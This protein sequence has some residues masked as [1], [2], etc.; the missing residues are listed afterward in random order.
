MAA[1]IQQHPVFIQAQNKASMYVNQLDKELTQYPVL[2]HFEQRTQIPKAYA[3]I[4]TL[5]LAVILH[6]FNPLASPVSNL[7][8][9]AIESPSPHDDVQWL[10]YWVVFGFLNFLESFAL[11][12]VLY[13]VPWYFAFKSAFI[14]WL[15]LPAFRG[16]Q[17]IYF[18]VLKP[19][20]Q[21]AT[22][23]HSRVVPVA[24]TSTSDH[25]D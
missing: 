16:A 11:R 17:T 20:L 3:V 6:A 2:N 8:G 5:S 12:A 1:Q 19:V 13:Y 22:A 15:Q 10:T 7:V 18:S 25:S 21:N 9:W 14:V 23:S 24:A 4:G